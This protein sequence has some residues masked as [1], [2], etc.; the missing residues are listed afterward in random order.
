M[1]ES[2]A[3]LPLRYRKRPREVEA[4]QYDGSMESQRAIV[5]WA[6]VKVEGYVDHGYY[7]AIH[8]LEGE[9]RARPGDWVVKGVA[10]EFYPVKPL[11]FETTYEVVDG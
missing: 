2:K 10:G 11:I 4:M 9:M 6:N 8:T 5:T 7:L 3:L 1:A